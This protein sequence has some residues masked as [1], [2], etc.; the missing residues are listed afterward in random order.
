MTRPLIT[1]DATNQ[2][3]GRLASAI[4]VL[5]MGKHLPTY[6]PEKDAGVWVCVEH[7]DAMRIHEKKMTQKIYYR[8]TGYLGNMKRTPMGDVWR[9][10]PASVL[11]MAV[12]NMLPKNKLQ[13]GR[14][15]R[16]KI[17]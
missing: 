17:S 2:A 13:K 5:L 4:A 7:V 10:N 15:K 11:Q 14:L 8:Y 16:L 6:R 1:I 12:K 9:K 3:P